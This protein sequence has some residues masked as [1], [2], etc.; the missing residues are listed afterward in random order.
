VRLIGGSRAAFADASQGR[1]D[2]ALYAQPAVEAGRI[3]MLTFLHE[4][5]VAIT[6]HRFGSPT[7][8]AE[9]LFG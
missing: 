7:P 5:A 6:A 2:V 1:A 3:E 8:L 9:G 4:Q